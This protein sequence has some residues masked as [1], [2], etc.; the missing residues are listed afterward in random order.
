[1]VRQHEEFV[2]L[3]ERYEEDEAYAG[4]VVSIWCWEAAKTQ[5]SL[6][7]DSFVPQV[8]LLPASFFPY[9]CPEHNCVHDNLSPVQT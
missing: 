5:G 6:L 7:K 3:F 2:W 1:M 4:I 8:L 9:V